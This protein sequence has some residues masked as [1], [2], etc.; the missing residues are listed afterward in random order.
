MNLGILR[1]IVVENLETVIDVLGW[2]FKTTQK[3][4]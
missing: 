4:F 1:R 3:N 2:V